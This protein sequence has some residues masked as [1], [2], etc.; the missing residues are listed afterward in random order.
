MHAE[1]SYFPR[2]SRDKRNGQ[3]RAISAALIYCFCE[4]AAVI[5]DRCVEDVSESVIRLRRPF[6]CH[7]NS[8]HVF[9]YVIVY[10]RMAGS[11][12]HLV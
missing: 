2:T 6:T 7:E 3:L 10:R 11:T 12:R 9:D 1:N 4:M 5:E 8:T